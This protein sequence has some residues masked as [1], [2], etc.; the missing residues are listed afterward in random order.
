MEYDWENDYEEWEG[1]HE[2][3]IFG[4]K[5]AQRARKFVHT[6]LTEEE[7][8]EARRAMIEAREKL[9]SQGVLKPKEFWRK[10]QEEGLEKPRQQNLLYASGMKSIGELLKNE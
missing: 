9:V 8:Q 4:N 7:A 6:K 3:N 1:L 2:T 5:P 10:Q